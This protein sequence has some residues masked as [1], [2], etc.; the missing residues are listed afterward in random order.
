MQIVNIKLKGQTPIMLVA[1]TL[2]DPLNPLTQAHKALTSIRG[3]NKTEDIL[4]EIAK[5]QYVNGI[6][7]NE[8]LNVY[9]P[10]QNIRA[11]M[12]GGAK[13]NKKGADFK[14]AVQIVG[15]KT[16]LIYDG[17]KTPEGLW[18]NLN[19]RD[20][21]TVVVNRSKVMAYRAIIPNWTLSFQIAYDEDMVNLDSIQDALTKAGRF[22]GLCGYRIEN[23]G[24]FGSFE[25]E[26]MT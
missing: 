8:D 10:N 14:R 21:R 11:S 5:S 25:V 12:I 6:Y 26:I 4:R 1:D 15:N 2:A 19:F 9:V 7:W 22:V 13:F 16:K 20:V 23:G 3:K 24:G 17:P 18:K